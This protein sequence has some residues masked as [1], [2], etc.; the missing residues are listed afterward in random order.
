MNHGNTA[1]TYGV[2]LCCTLEEDP[3]EG[4]TVWIDLAEVEDGDHVQNL[5]DGLTGRADDPYPDTW[6][7]EGTF[8]VVEVRGL[9]PRLSA[10]ASD[11]DGPLVDSL[12]DLAE[13]LQ[14]LEPEEVAP[15]LTW[16][17]SDAGSW[18]L[19]GYGGADWSIHPPEDVVFMFRL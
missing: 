5:I 4:N 1:P 6:N 2:L 19:P 18:W 8:E 13:V 10:I 17:E 12:A 14:M 9:G 7:E 16:A 3:R 11:M 15:F